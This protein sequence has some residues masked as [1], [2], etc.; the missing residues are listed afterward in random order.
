MDLGDRPLMT[1]RSWHRLRNAKGVPG[2]NSG[3][4]AFADPGC[5]M[6]NVGRS[7]G[8]EE[9]PKTIVVFVGHGF[10]SSRSNARNY[11]RAQSYA[12]SAPT[13]RCAGVFQGGNIQL[14]VQ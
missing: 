8:A 6:L 12:P 9:T 7:E 13:T 14:M 11:D 1:L 3:V 4:E 5:V 10:G 2:L